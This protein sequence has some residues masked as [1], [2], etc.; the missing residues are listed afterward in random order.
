M[1]YCVVCETVLNFEKDLKIIYVN[2]W[3]L[4]KHGYELIEEK[5]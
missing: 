4:K 3:W 1:A 5:K 2:E